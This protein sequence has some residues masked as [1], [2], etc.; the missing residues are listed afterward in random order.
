MAQ[1]EQRIWL[2]LFQ[3]E[4]T[5]VQTEADKLNLFQSFA[6]A[7]MTFC[8]IWSIFL[9]KQ[10]NIDK[11]AFRNRK[12]YLVIEMDECVY[13]AVINHVASILAGGKF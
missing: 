1:M 10:S 11:A 8:D 13:C 2:L 3:R 9:M 4:C 5:R 6:L 7:I 12:K